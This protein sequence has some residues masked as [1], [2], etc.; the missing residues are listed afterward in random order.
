MRQAPRCCQPAASPIT[1]LNPL[2][3]PAGLRLDGSNAALQSGLNDALSAKNRGGRG[4]GSLFGPE[5]MA[6]LALDPRGRAL[7]DDA[8]FMARFKAVGQHPEMLQAMLGDEKMQLVSR[9]GGSEAHLRTAHRRLVVAGAVALQAVSALAVAAAAPPAG[10]TR[11]S[12][13]PSQP[14]A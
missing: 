3:T 12:S 5:A 9:A 2:H 13:R 6:R 7:L 1:F 11:C 8:E 10:P 4:G 14:G